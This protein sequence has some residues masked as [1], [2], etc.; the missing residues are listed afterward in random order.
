[1]LQ[2]EKMQY[3]RLRV[4]GFIWGG[5]MEKLSDA[6]LKDRISKVLFRLKRRNV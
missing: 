5:K 2:I 6:T 3:W 1:M 4:S